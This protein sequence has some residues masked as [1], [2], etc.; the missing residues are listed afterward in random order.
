MGVGET[1]YGGGG[2]AVYKVNQDSIFDTIVGGPAG[3]NTLAIAG[4]GDQVMGANITGMTAVD[5]MAKTNFTAN[6]TANMAISGSAAGGDTIVLGAASQSV[7]A[8]GPG[9]KI[10]ASAVNAGAL[11]TGVGAGSTL[12]VTSGGT[13]V[14]NAADSV[15]TVKLDAA[16]NLTLNKMSFITAIGSSGADTIAAGAAYQTL[17]G[18]GGADTL[19]GFSGGYDTFRDKAS[20]L[21][22]DT[23][24][25]FLATDKIDVT[26]L[27]FAGAVL[28]VAA[29]GANTVVT[30]T[31][32]GT[33]AAF[34]LAGSYAAVGFHLASDGATG[35]LL[36]HS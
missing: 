22:G 13:V 34:T 28:K 23:I 36:T 29:S 33:K 25:V 16:T 17:T 30:L 32:G 4:G 12:E 15:S 1:A 6:T 2:N 35:T 18:G 3:T 21:N 24:K 5:L 19:I 9:E 31:S 26:D 27:A 7:I 11:V 10:K 20:G 8:G 14:L